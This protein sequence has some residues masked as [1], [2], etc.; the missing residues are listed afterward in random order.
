W[1]LSALSAADRTA[2]GSRARLFKLGLAFLAAASC[3]QS[4]QVNDGGGGSGTA[5]A[6]AG[7]GAGSAGSGSAGTGGRR[8]TA[9]GGTGASGASGL[10]VPAQGALLGAFVGTGTI[11]QLET[12]L[13]RKLAVSHNF[14]GW[15][16]DYTTW[17]RSTLAGGYIPLVTWETWTNGVGYSLDDIIN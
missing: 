4:S 6:G 7:G 1:M 11:A 16:D 14:F 8:G 5:A 10:L 3:A 17:I 2:T 12:T 15:T 9:A 13:G